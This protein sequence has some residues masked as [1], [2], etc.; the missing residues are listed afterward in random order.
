[1]P[2]PNWVADTECTERYR[3]TFH[4]A[5]TSDFKMELLHFFGQF[6]GIAMRSKIT[7]DLAFP[8]YIW[9]AIVRETLTERDLLSFDSP[10]GEFI[11][12]LSAI[13]KQIQEEE[14]KLLQSEEEEEKEREG[15]GDP[16]NEV[17]VSEEGVGGVNG[18]PRKTAAERERQQQETPSPSPDPDQRKLAINTPDPMMGDTKGQLD[19]MGD[20]FSLLDADGETV[21]CLQESAQA[22]IEDLNW[23]ATRSDGVVVELIP[24]GASIAVELGDIGE[25]LSLYVET[26]LTESKR[27]IDQ[28]RNGLISIVP[29]SCLSLLNW[30][31]LQNLVC[32]A[33]VIDVGRLKANTEYDDDLTA[34]DSHIL[35][36]WE[37]LEEMTEEMK[38]AFLRF[39]WARP[40]LPPKGVEFNQKMRILSVVGDDASIKP[41]Q[42]L[43]KAH[44][45]FF[46]INLPKYST[47]DLMRD[48]ILYAITSCTE[49]DADFRTTE[50]DIPGWSLEGGF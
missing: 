11:L 40:T 21:R 34:E 29:D 49:M 28:F 17:S 35:M 25:Y 4:P 41:D 2:T 20:S 27:A 10:V 44:T 42:Y 1:M 46:S 6:V 32:G 30:E 50:A 47:K 39:V 18:T 13:H 9:K 48:K 8:S 37:I 19:E 38:S 36:F 24:N 45:C 14:L 23:T 7:L 33:R 15:S 26:R 5:A 43:P 31:E 12:R 3:Y 22:L 16:Q